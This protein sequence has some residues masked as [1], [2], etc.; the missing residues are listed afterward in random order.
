MCLLKY[1]RRFFAF[2]EVIPDKLVPSK[3]EL[4]ELIEGVLNDPARAY[5]AAKD[6]GE[7]VNEIIMHESS[8][9]YAFKKGVMITLGIDNIL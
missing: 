4:K 8:I 2:S 7:E 6:F 3:S 1:A 9:L 5:E